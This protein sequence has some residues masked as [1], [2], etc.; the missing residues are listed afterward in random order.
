MSRRA[1][2]YLAVVILF[3]LAVTALVVFRGGSAEEIVQWGRGKRKVSEAAYYKTKVANIIGNW[4]KTQRE[5]RR[6]REGRI[7]GVYNVYL[8]FD[9][10]VPAVWIERD[11]EVDAANYVELPGRV[12][13]K[14]YRCSGGGN[15]EMPQ[16]VRLKMR[17]FNTRQHYPEMIL[18]VGEAKGSGH[19]SFDFN[20]SAFGS[21]S[22]S[23]WFRLPSYGKTVEDGRDYYDSIVVSDE[24]YERYR[25]RIDAN[26]SVGKEQ[27][28]ASAVS[29]NIARWLGVE[30]RLY[31]RIEEE[32]MRQGLSLRELE[33]VVGPDYTGAHAEVTGYRDSAI[34]KF[35]GGRRRREAYLQIDY[36]GE[37]VWYVKSA[38][39]P[40]FPR[41]QRGG[42]LELEFVVC[43]SGE[44]PRGEQK[45]WLEKGRKL[46]ESV[47]RPES[48]WRVT[49]ANGATVEFIG[50]CESPSVGK[51]WWGPDGS[52][53]G[54]EPYC[55]RESVLRERKNRAVFEIAYK[56][57]QPPGGG[58]MRAS[59]QGS[60]GSGYHRILDKYGNS[61]DDL[62]AE[63]YVFD[64]DREKTTLR[65]ELRVGQ[66]DA[67]SVEFRNISLVRGEDKGFEIKTGE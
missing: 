17:G 34:Q 7:I 20:S 31:K 26:G 19:I 57:Y 36:V 45:Q 33:V 37:D 42:P 27:D 30:R 44:I 50:V 4:R 1:I 67:E 66:G 51:Q 8:V 55:R 60:R 14:V 48:K 59:M 22:S 41:T 49:L 11:C 12:E 5:A 16:K 40:R 46:R 13:W 2:F 54:Y 32:V 52:L 29:E 35:F 65:L 21:G 23:G 39:H 15:E 24:E 18:F 62:H 53:L 43:A 47:I 64:K 63:A 61:I 6:D 28:D 38:S 58:G 9:T 10:S 3:L 56:I 25:Q